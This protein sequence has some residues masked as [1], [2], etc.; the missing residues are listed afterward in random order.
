M[1]Q[2]DRWQTV[3]YLIRH[4]EAK[5]EHDSGGRKLIYGPEAPLSDTGRQQIGS[6]AK[7]I[8][9]SGVVLD[10]I[11]T[12]HFPRALDSAHILAD[13]FK[14]S[15]A[16]VIL[17][18]QLGEV[19]VPGWYG[20]P[21]AELDAINGDIDSVPPRSKDQETLAQLDQRVMSAYKEILQRENWRSIGI[22]SHGYPIRIL[23]YRINNPE[24]SLPPVSVLNAYDVDRGEGWKILLDGNRS[25]V[26]AETITYKE[27]GVRREREY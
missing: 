17:S 20:V 26:K 2:Q 5:Y 6:L 22:V 14:I 9:R 24:G 25:V 11:Y 27:G 18:S 1:N 16:N 12:S 23:A 21:F 13:K 10:V 15:P 4:G 19:Q 7:I 8:Q 3:V